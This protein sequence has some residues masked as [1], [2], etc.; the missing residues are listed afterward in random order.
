VGSVESASWRRNHLLHPMNNHGQKQ[1]PK[2]WTA[3]DA[4]KGGIIAD[5]SGRLW[6]I[7]CVE[8]DGS[9]HVT[10]GAVIAPDERHHWTLFKPNGK[11]HRS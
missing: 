3:D 1:Q 11:D 2:D 5:E 7:Q 8:F 9:V 6:A 10:T 4:C